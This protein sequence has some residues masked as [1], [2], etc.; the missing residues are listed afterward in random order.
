MIVILGV[1]AAASRDRGRG[2]AT[3][4]LNALPIAGDL[5]RFFQA[6]VPQ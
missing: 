1:A 5:G 4:S 3:S 2:A 6:R